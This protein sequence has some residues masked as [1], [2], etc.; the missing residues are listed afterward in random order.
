MIVALHTEDNYALR[1]LCQVLGLA[2]SSFYYQP[3]ATDAG[4]LKAQSV[5][6]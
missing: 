1:T 6:D 3:Q 4:R 2:R 5:D